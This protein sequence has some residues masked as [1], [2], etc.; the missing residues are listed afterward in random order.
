MYGFRHR[1]RTLVSRDPNSDQTSLRQVP[2]EIFL[3]RFSPNSCRIFTAF[4]SW[5]GFMNTYFRAFASTVWMFCWL[6]RAEKRSLME[7]RGS[8]SVYI[9][10][11]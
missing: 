2:V 9:C 6:L 3:D 7:F 1:D 8:L 5:A 4:S 10:G 11:V